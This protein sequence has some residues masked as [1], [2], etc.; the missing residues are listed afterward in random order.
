MTV[1]DFKLIFASVIVFGFFPI[2]NNILINRI[3]RTMIYEGSTFIGAVLELKKEFYVSMVQYLIGEGSS[4]KFLDSDFQLTKSIDVHSGRIIAIFCHNDRIYSADSVGVC[5]VWDIKND[6]KW[7]QTMKRQNSFS[8]FS[9]SS[10][11]SF[12]LG[13]TCVGGL[14]KASLDI[15]NSDTL[16]HQYSIS[17]IDPRGVYSSTFFHGDHIMGGYGN[18][19]AILGGYG[20]VHIYDIHERMHVTSF[21]AHSGPVLSIALWYADDTTH[22]GDGCSGSSELQSDWARAHLCVVATGGEDKQILLWDAVDFTGVKF[23]HSN[24]KLFR[25]HQSAVTHLQTAHL[26]LN[27]LRWGVLCSGSRDRTIRVWDICSGSQ[28]YMFNEYNSMVSCLHMMRHTVPVPRQSSIPSLT[29][30]VHSVLLAAV[31]YDNGLLKTF[32][33]S[34]ELIYMRRQIFFRFLCGYDLL[35]LVERSGRI[36][37]DSCVIETEGSEI[38]REGSG[39][40]ELGNAL[41]QMN[42]ENNVN[43]PVYACLSI[44]ELCRCICAYV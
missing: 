38:A 30:P 32:D 29:P 15:W 25:G 34:A 42:I 43:G 19:V 18:N 31:C 1:I 26:S 37:H 4:L 17:N 24:T 11:G 20:A 27:G 12:L 13:A 44:E 14:N 33:L 6:F 22:T 10:G 23:V 9:I 41:A 7:I 35:M 28:L 16:L 39:L 8:A 36:S 2:K 21:S 40:D 5:N 3:F